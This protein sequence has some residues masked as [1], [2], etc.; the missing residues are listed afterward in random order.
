MDKTFKKFL[1]RGLSLSTVGVEHCEDKEPYFCTPKGASIF[2]W[3]GVDGIH[4]CFIRGSGSMVFAVSPMNEASD[5]VHPLARNFADFLR[6]LLACGDVAALEQ[7][8]MWREAQ[9]ETFLRENPP[10]QEQR[11]QLAEAASELK[12]S[13]MEHRGLISKSYKHRLSIAKSSTQRNTTML[14]ESRR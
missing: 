7:A 5:F 11:E 3:T 8:W 1:Q 6:L 4:F 13:P 12:L 9:F 14:W 10:T 2:G